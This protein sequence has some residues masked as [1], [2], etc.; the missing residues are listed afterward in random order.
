MK[1]IIVTTRTNW[2]SE[3]IR[4]GMLSADSSQDSQ[5]RVIR[6]YGFDIPEPALASHAW[7]MP[8]SHAAH[9]RLTLPQM[10]L[11]APGENWLPSIPYHMRGRHIESMKVSELLSEGTWNTPRVIKPA[12]AK[13]PNLPVKLWDYQEFKEVA[14][15]LHPD[16]NVQV[17][18]RWIP[19]NY[20]HRFYVVHGKIE[21]GSPYLIDDV[22]WN[23]GLSWHHYE[24]AFSYARAVVE[25]LGTHQ[26]ESYVLDVGLDTSTDKWLVVEGNPSWCS[27]F[28]GAS[29]PAVIEAI[30]ISGFA[31]SNW[32]W[33]PDPQLV[34]VN[35]KKKK[36]EI[37]PLPN[38]RC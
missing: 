29:I 7:W 12:E 38:Y 32:A 19:F 18:S 26:P 2:V 23:D 10:T 21:T 15:L 33:N 37:S 16:S 25:E 8:A 27:G 17:S 5:F 31:D 13:I 6:D 30:H 4:E 36:L 11:T 20:E 28:Y 1:D 34:W 3:E 14:D 9:V 22:T 35:E 24:D